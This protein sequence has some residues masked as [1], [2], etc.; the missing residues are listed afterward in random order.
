MVGRNKTFK[1]SGGIEI[2]VSEPW[3][4]HKILRDESLPE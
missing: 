2:E 4:E 1:N 3:V